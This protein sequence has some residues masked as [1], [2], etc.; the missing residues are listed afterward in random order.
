MKMYQDWDRGLILRRVKA[1]E[2]MKEYNASYDKMFDDS[3]D[4][5]YQQVLEERS[6][7]LR[8]IFKHVGRGV[9]IE[10]TLRCEF[11]DRISIGDGVNVGCDC[12]M[13]DG[14]GITIGDQTYIGPRVAIYTSNHA[15][16]PDERLAGAC[17]DLPVKIGE[18]SWIGGGSIINAGSSIGSG[19]VIG[20]GSV[21]RGRIPSGVVASGVPC[22]VIRKITE[23]DKTGFTG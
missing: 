21:V 19:T 23:A 17:W 13:F 15:T 2:V 8:R 18:R 10:Q 6:D 5:P 16:D 4:T 9:H 12:I 20:S 11:G 3:D 14:G 22:R 7:I 1:V